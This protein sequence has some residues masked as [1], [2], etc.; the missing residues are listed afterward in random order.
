MSSSVELDDKGSSKAIEQEVRSLEA[1]R[2][3]AMHSFDLPALEAL[4][5]DELIYTHASTLVEDKATF[6]ARFMGDRRRMD[7]IQK[8]HRVEES[9]RV[10]G[11]T[12]LITGN[13]TLEDGVLPAWAKRAKKNVHRR[14]L[15][16]WTKTAQGWKF[17]AYQSADI[18]E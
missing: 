8:F 7:N 13:F 10:Y 3:R 11:D 16:V 18:P 14:Y 6:M 9:F 15:S 12:A 17:V 5:H 4:F 1:E 2:W